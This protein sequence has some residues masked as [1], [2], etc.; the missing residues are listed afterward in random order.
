MR[1][2]TVKTDFGVTHINP[3]HVMAV[4]PYPKEDFRD[5]PLFEPASTI[6][7]SSEFG[8]HDGVLHCEEE[9][10]KI[11]NRCENG[12]LRAFQASRGGPF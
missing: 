8:P 9:P 5:D 10:D 1:F 3:N 7:L 4:A 11:R 2:I 6:Y 12:I